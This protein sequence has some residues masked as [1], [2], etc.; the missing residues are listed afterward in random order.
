VPAGK[1]NDD[2]LLHHSQN[3]RREFLK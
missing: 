2:I 1:S 3:A